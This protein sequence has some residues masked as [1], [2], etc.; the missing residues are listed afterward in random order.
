MSPSIYSTRK[1]IATATAPGLCLPESLL[2][3]S[4]TRPQK[5]STKKARSAKPPQELL[6]HSSAHRTLDYT[7][8]EDGPKDAGSSLRH[9][10][11]VFDP[12]TGQLQVV[13]GRKMVVRG[14]VR[15]QQAS[16][17]AM[18]EWADKKV[19]CTVPML[20]TAQT[21]DLPQ[22]AMDLKNDLGET[23]GTK[24]AK[25]AIL[26]LT[27]NA[28]SP[29]KRAGGSDAKPAAL[30]AGSLALMESLKETTAN[31]ASREELQAAVDMAKPVPKGHLDADEIQNVYVP[32][33]I[34][35]AEVLT[36]IPVR[37]WQQAANTKQPLQVYSRFVA[38]RVNR[39]ADHEDALQRLRLLRYLY[40]VILYWHSARPG[41]E[42]GTK[43]APPKDKLKADM[44][45]APDGVL[46]NIRR[47]FT[48]NGVLR[49]FHVDLLMTHCCVFA[50]ILDGFEVNTLDLRE[51]LKLEQKE[52]N[53]YFMEIGAR[54]SVQKS[55][56]KT[57]HIAKLS[58]PL[59]FP[60]LRQRRRR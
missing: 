31:M 54:V 49:K 8:K 45:G 26:A 38:H 41:R 4:Y 43:Q 59:R 36:S 23:F 50:S 13:E 15:S 57:G 22:T 46:E 29:R 40:W 19:T 48:D 44:D 7:G 52:L 27:E 32:E 39:I 16:A 21:A 18:G 2:F 35:G 60:Q 20:D 47:K 51:D 5:T 25:K 42:R 12:A 33:E 14:S 24:K 37:D 28:I 9:Y 10:I 58:L 56:D 3:N 34:I 17:E 30:D 6:L 11:G 1:L 53:Q 55:E